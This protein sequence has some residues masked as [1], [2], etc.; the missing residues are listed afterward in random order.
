MGLIAD[1]KAFKAAYSMLTDDQIERFFPGQEAQARKAIESL[2]W[3]LGDSLSYDRALELYLTVAVRVTMSFE[4]ERIHSTLKLRFSDIMPDNK[5]LTV[6]DC[7]GRIKKNYDYIH[8]A[9][10]PKQ[11]ALD[12]LFDSQNE[13]SFTKNEERSKDAL[14]RPGF[15]TDPHNPIY[16]H[17]AD[18]SYGYLNL[19]Y[20]TGHLP[21][22]WRRVGS[23][24]IDAD[25][26]PIDEY[27][28]L[29]PDGNLYSTIYVNMY[30]RANTRYCPYGLIGNGLEP[31]PETDAD[32]G[33]QNTAEK[34]ESSEDEEYLMFLQ[35]YSS[36]LAQSDNKGKPEKNRTLE[37]EREPEEHQKSQRCSA[38]K[39]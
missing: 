17:S 15:G 7:I 23:F 8:N 16:A 13:S 12:S 22:T 36:D 5:A 26:E 10:T 33:K 14:R 28:L 21:L 4:K 31:V 2:V 27:E 18:G 24:V 6:I 34:D 39:I 9:N 1:N 37:A 29:L 30:S 32:V 19:L 38:R 3:L 11:R 35:R 25:D 20:T